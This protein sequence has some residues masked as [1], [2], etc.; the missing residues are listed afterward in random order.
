MPR[1]PSRPEPTHTLTLSP[2]TTHCPECGH[3]LGAD[4]ANHR[5]VT[6]LDAITRLTLEVRRCPQAGGSRFRV[7]FRPEAEPHL[8]LPH[9]EFGLDVL[10]LAGRLRHGEHRSVPEIHRDLTARGVAVSERTVTNLLDR[11]DERKALSVADPGRRRPLL[12]RQGRVVLALDGLPP[13]VGHEVLGVLRDCLS[14]TILLARSLRSAKAADL[15]VL[16]TE[17]RRALPVPVTGV[18]SD[19]QGSIRKAVARALPGVP[20]QWCHFHDLREAARPISEADRHAQKELPKRVRGV[21]QIERAA[22]EDADPEAE[23][24]RGYCAA[25]RAALTDDGLPPLAAAGRKL[26]D[27][28]AKIAASLDRVSGRA[29]RL[30]GGWRRLAALLHRGLDETAALWPPVRAAFRGVK[31]VARVLKNPSEPSARQVRRQL[32]RVLSPLRR[33]AAE[34][35]EGSVRSPWR[36]FATVTKSYWPGLF[37]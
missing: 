27:R 36:P 32:T 35:A 16:R 26:H 17:V 21:R 19:G 29:K 24:V 6:T 22:A 15:S 14:G 4:Y 37:A 10:T 31:R 12:E 28:L 20:H 30:P 5:T 34:A 23:V 8:A 18:I 7:P 3:R 33:E 13:D 2:V 25:V 1:T 9:H 11:Y